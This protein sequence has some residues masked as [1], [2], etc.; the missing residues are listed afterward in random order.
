MIDFQK[1]VSRLGSEIVL[2]EVNYFQTTGN[3]KM[4]LH[5]H[6]GQLHIACFER[7]SGIYLINGIVRKIHPGVIQIVYPGE[8]HEFIP[9]RKRPYRACF[10]HLTWYGELPTNL[11]KE[12]RLPRKERYSFFRLCQ[13]LDFSCHRGVIRPGGAF[14][15]YSLLLR[16]FGE[17]QRLG[18]QLAAP[19]TPVSVCGLDKE[20]NPVI[21]ALVGP[22]FAYP[23][24]DALAEKVGMSRRRLTRLFRQHTGCGIKQYFL[25]NVM[26]Y[27]EFMMQNGEYGSAEI[28]RQCGYSTT[29]NF[30]LAFHNYRKKHPNGMKSPLM[31]VWKPTKMIND[32]K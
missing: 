9:D 3:E 27:A 17:I 15:L 12:L 6:P 23:G 26:R 13:E 24:I 28:A 19:D 7:G 11:P 8:R 21:S 16:F 32:P 18:A 29:Q 30:L 20:L 2:L 10:L 31:T 4:P 22:P 5:A 14:E 25:G 1:W